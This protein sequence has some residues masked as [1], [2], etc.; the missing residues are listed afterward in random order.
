VPIGGGTPTTLASMQDSPA[1]IAVDAAN[2]YWTTFANAGTVMKVPI[3]G[4]TPT[5]LASGQPNPNDIAVD[6][7]SVYWTN[8]AGTVMKVAK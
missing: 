7:T 4:G 3:G 6:A 5:T 8:Y 1:G 2:V